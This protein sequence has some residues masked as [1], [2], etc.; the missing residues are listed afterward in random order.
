[1][2]IFHLLKMTSKCFHPA[3]VEVGGLPGL[4]DRYPGAIAYHNVT[5]DITTSHNTTYDVTSLVSEAT[6]S[7]GRPRDDAFV[8]FRDPVTSD[9]PWPGV[10]FRSTFASL[11]YWCAD[12]VLLQALPFISLNNRGCTCSCRARLK[13]LKGINL[14]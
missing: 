12:Q 1:M 3:F 13:H 2:A 9:L 10:I 7:C 11:W 5:E 8:F 6:S 14:E 4:Y